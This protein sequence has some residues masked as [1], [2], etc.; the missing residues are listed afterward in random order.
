MAKLIINN[1]NNNN[2]LNMNNNNNLFPSLFSNLGT[3]N[4]N[5]FFSNFPKK[6]E[7][8]HWDLDESV[9]K[10][11]TVFSNIDNN[12]VHKFID[13]GYKYKLSVKVP[14]VGNNLSV[15]VNNNV[16]KIEYSE[17]VENNNYQGCYEFT[18]PKD[19]D[20][21]K[22]EAELGSDNTITVFVYKKQNIDNNKNRKIH[23]KRNHKNN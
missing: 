9:F 5:D 23:I 3:L 14:V 20:L 10:K 1:N 21:N 16:L 7:T 8:F 19:G 4:W 15:T 11:P 13:L 6:D 18:I 22:I 17:K 2:N 12:F